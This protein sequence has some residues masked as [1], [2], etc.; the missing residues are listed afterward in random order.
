MKHARKDYDRIQDPAGLIPDNEP[1]FLVRGQDKMGWIVCV[2]WAILH[3]ITTGD[4]RLTMLALIHGAS[5]M[6]WAKK[7]ADAP[8]EA[9]GFLP[10]TTDDK[11]GR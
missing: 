4:K 2:V 7:D 6:T 8:E 10:L 3:F 5:M 11:E 1:V 9:Y